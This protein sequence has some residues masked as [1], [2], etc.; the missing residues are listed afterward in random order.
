MRQLASITAIA[1]LA[2]VPLAAAAGDGAAP[3]PAGEE[4]V[5][6]HSL[7]NEPLPMDLRPDQ[8]ITEAVAAFHASGE[9]PY[10]GDPERIAAGQEIYKRLCQACHL[11]DGVGRI[12]PSI[13]DDAWKYPRGGTDVGNFEIIYAGGAGAMQAFGQRIDQDAILEVMAFIETLIVE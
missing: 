13:A 8:Q 7:D 12:G 5:F 3:E 2:A 11:P 9:N 1:A 4:I 6:R 10:S